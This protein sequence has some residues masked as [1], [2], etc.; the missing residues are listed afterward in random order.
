MT[1]HKK[2]VSAF[3]YLG[4]FSNASGSKLNDVENDAK[5]RTL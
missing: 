1:I 5:S 2:F 4:E 3:G